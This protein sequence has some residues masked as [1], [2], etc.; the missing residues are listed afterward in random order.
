MTNDFDALVSAYID[1][2]A[3]PEE[4]AL[5]E[6]DP[7]LRAEA[8]ALAVVIDR[9]AYELPVPPPGL[10]QAQIGTALAAFDQ[11]APVSEEA[12]P[13]GAVLGDLATHRAGR[14]RTALPQHRG[15]VPAWLGAAAAMLVAVAGIGWV[16]QAGDSDDESADTFASADQDESTESESAADG[17]AM[18]TTEAMAEQSQAVAAEADAMEAATDDDAS[19]AAPESDTSGRDQSSTTSVEGGFFPD[20]DAKTRNDARLN[21]T[22]PPT[23]AVLADLTAG[24]L[25]DPALSLCGP[26]VDVGP[27]Q[28][29]IGMVPISIGDQQGEILV[30]ESTDDSERS[31]LI[32]ESDVVDGGQPTCGPLE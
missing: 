21:L 13:A 12:P 11:L 32:V 29:L 9:V 5:I 1:G 19:D 25:L 4:V 7:V 17:E 31:L 14:R 20:E 24:P 6:G 16:V 10:R 15:G 26:Y 3:T 18:N 8:E 23:E 28:S 27:G 30:Y 2:Q 22:A